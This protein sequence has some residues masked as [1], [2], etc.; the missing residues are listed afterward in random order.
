MAKVV[1][2]SFKELQK[3]VAKAAYAL[4]MEYGYEKTTMRMIFENAQDLSKNQRIF[5][6]INRL[7]HPTNP[8]AR[9]FQRNDVNESDSRQSQKNVI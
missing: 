9:D 8:R 7:R 2:R 5:I 4:F 1:S 3:D 6:E